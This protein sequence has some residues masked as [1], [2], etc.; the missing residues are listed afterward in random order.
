MVPGEVCINAVVAYHF[1]VPVKDI[2]N[3]AFDK[4]NGRDTFRDRFMVLMALIME[5]YGVSIIDINFGG[6]DERSF[7]VSAIEFI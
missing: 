1:E 2:H 5:S 3:Q 7:E 4:V 6:G